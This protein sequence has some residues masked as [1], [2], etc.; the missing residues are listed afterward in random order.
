L[1]AVDGSEVV[2]EGGTATFNPLTNANADGDD[3]GAQTALMAAASAEGAWGA[4]RWATLKD[5]K[6][7]DDAANYTTT[8]A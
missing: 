2:A 6:K 3:A 7:N 1:K 5:G 8:K 4:V